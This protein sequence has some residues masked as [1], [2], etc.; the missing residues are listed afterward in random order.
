[1]T[2]KERT[3][4]M[5]A[6]YGEVCKRAEAAKI[7]HCSPQTINAMLSDGR[8]DWACGGEKVDVR[9]IASYICA[10]AEIEA[11]ARRRRYCRR[12]GTK[13]SV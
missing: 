13:W 2:L 8:L 3:D 11:E 5:I 4:D 6:R 7:L 12:H 1:M 9:S 10:P